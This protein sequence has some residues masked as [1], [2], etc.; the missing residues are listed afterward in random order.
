MEN[1]SSVGVIE[2]SQEEMIKTDGGLI[3]FNVELIQWA[4]SE[5]K[6]GVHD[7]YYDK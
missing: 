3:M 7:G 1:L 2:L 5:F 4:Y 6:K